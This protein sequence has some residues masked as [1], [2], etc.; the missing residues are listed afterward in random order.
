MTSGHAFVFFPE[1]PLEI[2]WEFHKELRLL[3]LWGARAARRLRA[4]AE[5]ANGPRVKTQGPFRS[6][7]TMKDPSQASL[8]QT[9]KGQADTMIR[10]P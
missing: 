6:R 7:E 10:L 2:F 3:E 4:C 9:K 1:A 8:A 5:I